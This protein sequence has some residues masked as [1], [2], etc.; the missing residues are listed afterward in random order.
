MAKGLF[1]KK[2]LHDLREEAS[3]K[4]EGLQRTLTGGNLMMLGIGAII[5]AGI[6]VMT[7]QAAA[8]YAGPGVVL[9]FLFAAL[10]CVFA[11]FCY[12]EFAS[13]I[14]VAGG[15]YSYSYI[16]LGEI[17]AWTIGWAMTLEYLFSS[18]T[19][20]VAWSEY[21]GSFLG[22]FG[23][24]LSQRFS[25]APFIYDSAIG[26]MKSGALIN[27]PAMIIMGLIGGLIALGIQTVSRFNNIIVV[28]K[29]AVIIL[30]IGC[31]IAY[32]NVANWTP[33][34]PSNTGVFGEF[35]FSGILRGAG[36]VFYA[37]I[38][39]DALAM[40]AQEARNPQKDMSFGMLGSLTVSAVAYILVALVLTGIVGYQLLGGAAPF[41]VAI[42]ALGPKFLW[43]R[44][45]AKFGILASLTSV[46]LVML[47]GQTRIFYAMAHDGLLPKFFGKVHKKTRTPFYN[48]IFLTAAGMIVCGLF[49]VGIIGQLVSIGTLLAFAMVCFGVLILRYRQPSVHRPFKVPFFPWIPL[50]GTLICVIQMI[51]LPKVIWTM[52]VLWIFLGYAI[53]FSF[54]IRNSV[55]RKKRK[56]G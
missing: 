23:I 10:I 19:V 16:T 20:A 11:A 34:I 37:Y 49:P 9:S 17:V 14:P 41:G 46:I 22:D 44:Y 29:F 47:L 28:I 30:F 50:A 21:L 38:G 26:W 39:F 13:M 43:L 31:G 5:G 52:L 18:A 24:R 42:D 15:A 45:V 27:V 53:Y 8:L 33:F 55:L 35:G 1:I 2:N 48:T 3:N 36:V 4:K 32:V 7:G 25:E 51:L 6:F 40:L 12:A 54:G 56:R